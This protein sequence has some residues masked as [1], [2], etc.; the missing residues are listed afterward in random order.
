[1]KQTTCGKCGSDTIIPRARVPERGEGNW[2][3]ELQ[4]QVD[5]KPHAML[6]KGA[7]RS[8]VYARVCCGCGYTE[9]YAEYTSG[10]W[11]AYQESLKRPNQ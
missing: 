2:T 11:E 8:P 9:L 5:S 10:L 6:F 1:M 7:F 3:H 4:V